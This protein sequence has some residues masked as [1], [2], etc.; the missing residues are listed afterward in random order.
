MGLAGRADIGEG[1][2]LLDH[3]L[4][5]VGAEFLLGNER[6]LRR[7]LIVALKATRCNKKCACHQH[8][9]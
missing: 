3:S 8:L 1:C 7:M 9:P 5:A 6:R 4:A 2:G